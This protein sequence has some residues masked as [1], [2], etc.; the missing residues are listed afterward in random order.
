MPFVLL[1]LILVV[2]VILYLTFANNEGDPSL[3]PRPFSNIG[4][5][6]SQTDDNDPRTDQ[7]DKSGHDPEQE[8][9]STINSESTGSDK[10]V[11]SADKSVD[12]NADPEHT[13]QSMEELT[14]FYRREA[15][16]LTGIK[17]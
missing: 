6:A 13:F 2:A 3:K 12:E 5:G 1:G 10:E 16:K 4:G 9:P 11:K 17:H 7:G 14:E 15:E 8:N